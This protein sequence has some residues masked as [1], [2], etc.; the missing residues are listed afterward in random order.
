[1]KCPYTKRYGNCNDCKLYDKEDRG[2][3][4]YYQK[5]DGKIIITVTKKGETNV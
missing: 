3:C 4:P 1:M 5:E 2:R